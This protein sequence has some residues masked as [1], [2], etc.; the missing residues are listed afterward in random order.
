MWGAQRLTPEQR[1]AEVS[2]EASSTATVRLPAF[3]PCGCGDSTCLGWWRW[4]VDGEQYWFFEYLQQKSP[5]MTDYSRDVYRH[6]LAV[7]A[8]REGYIY[9]LNVS[10][11]NSQWGE[12]RMERQMPWCHTLTRDWGPFQMEGA[13]KEAIDSFR[14]TPVTSEYVPPWKD[15][16]RFW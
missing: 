15:P 1:L 10:T 3:A 7:S 4:Q 9:T 14:F 8:S 16:W 11:L 2:I 13:I 6:S 12:V 5:T